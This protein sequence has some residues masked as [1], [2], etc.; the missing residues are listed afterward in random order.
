V[1]HGT[2]DVRFGSKADIAG[3]RM[4]YRLLKGREFI[5]SIPLRQAKP[6]LSVGMDYRPARNGLR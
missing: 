2:L 3:T 5:E 4:S 6:R 1:R